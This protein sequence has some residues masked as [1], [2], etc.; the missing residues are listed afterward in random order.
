VVKDLLA[1]LKAGS[2][3]D[4]IIPL[5]R[6]GYFVPETKK[7]DELLRE[8][9]E[10]HIQM[11][12]VIDEYGGTAGL[13]T[14]EDLVEEIVGEI[15]DEYDTEEALYEKI[16]D[17]EAIFD[18][19]ASIHDVNEIMDLHLD[20]EE[21]DTLGGLVYDRLGKVPVVGD[22]VRV[23]GCVVSVLATHGRR[24]MKVRVRLVQPNGQQA[25][26]SAA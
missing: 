5:L 13:I 2:L 25:E 23:N 6:P 3:N 24:V 7:T 9:Q 11:A 15:Q 8:L 4:S 20:D 12:I 18:A 14:L 22:E 10:K 21:F 16:S 19:R 26:E 17:R 1:P